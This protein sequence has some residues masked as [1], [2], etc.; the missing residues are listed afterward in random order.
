MDQHRQQAHPNVS[1][2]VK[3]ALWLGVITG[4]EI[5][6]SYTKMADAAKIASLLVLMIVKFIGVVG[7]FMHLKFDNPVLRKPFITGILLAGFVYSAVL[8]SLIL[9]SR[10]NVGP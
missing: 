2:Y 9:H 4:V 5:A 7:Y 3:V 8:M 6:I 1:T 10:G